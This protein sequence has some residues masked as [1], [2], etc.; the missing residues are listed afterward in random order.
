M[1]SRFRASSTARKIGPETNPPFWFRTRL[2]KPEFTSS[3]KL[4][5]ESISVRARLQ[6]CRKC[7]Q[8]NVGFSPCGIFPKK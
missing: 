5:K 6:S 7:P 8:K 1:Q 2:H 3:K 4:D